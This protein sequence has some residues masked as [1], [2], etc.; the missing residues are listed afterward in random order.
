MNKVIILLLSILLVFGLF[1]GCNADNTDS[2]STVE[3]TESTTSDNSSSGTTTEGTDSDT[4]SNTSSDTP[5]SESSKD[6]SSGSSTESSSS[7]LTISD[8]LELWGTVSI[9]VETKPE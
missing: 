8:I 1:V 5:S 7:E 3:S 4:T 2:N 9:E 6:G